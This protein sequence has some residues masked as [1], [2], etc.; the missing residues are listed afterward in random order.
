MT[1]T[2]PGPR[3]SKLGSGELQ[4][5]PGSSADSGDQ[6]EGEQREPAQHCHQPR[7]SL[8]FRLLV[9]GTRWKLFNKREL[10]A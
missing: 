8:S 9:G 7:R 5:T 2:P 3:L 1:W 4:D 10:L 6:G